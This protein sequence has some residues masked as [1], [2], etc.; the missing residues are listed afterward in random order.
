[1]VEML[2]GKEV[3][4]GEEKRCEEGEKFEHFWEIFSG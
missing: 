1:M 2:E 4:G 3:E